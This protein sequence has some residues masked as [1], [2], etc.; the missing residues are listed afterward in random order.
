[1]LV[2]VPLES[3]FVFIKCRKFECVLLP[4]FIPNNELTKACLNYAKGMLLFISTILSYSM[5]NY[6]GSD[7]VIELWSSGH[8]LL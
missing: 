2:I 7:I 6:L 4:Q 5:P 1:M 8:T 3:F